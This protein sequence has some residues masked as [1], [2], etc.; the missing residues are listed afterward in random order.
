MSTS[1]ATTT[2]TEDLHEDKSSRYHQLVQKKA[3]LEKKLNEKYEQL[4]Q[5][6][7]K[8]S[9][10]FKNISSISWNMNHIQ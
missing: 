1:I 2:K 8:V 10:K 6:C 5:L 9:K 3:S 7:Q 4:H